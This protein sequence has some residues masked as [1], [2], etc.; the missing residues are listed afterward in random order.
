MRGYAQALRAVGQALET[1]NLGD[2][3][4]EPDGDGYRI[5]GASIAKSLGLIKS[6]GGSLTAIEPGIRVT[7]MELSYSLSDVERLE[8]EGRTRRLKAQGA[9]DTSQLSQALRVIGCYLNQKYSRLL[10]LSRKGKNFEVL[11]ES[12]LGSRYSEY[13]TAADLYN[14]WV[15]FYLQ[16]AVRCA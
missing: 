8:R 9:T 10:R 6:V 14:L 7:P 13:F 15:R 12:S 2:F 5:T 11:Y 3:S 16:R 1:L 4:V